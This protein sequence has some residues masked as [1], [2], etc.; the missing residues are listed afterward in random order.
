MNLTD[1]ELGYLAGFID[2][3]GSLI[4]NKREHVGY[5]EKRYISYSAYLDIGNTNKECLEFIKKILNISSSIYENQCSGNRKLAYR[6]RISYKQAKPL[7]EALK[8]RLIVKRKI[9]EVFL[10]YQDKSF[11]KEK[12]FLE[13]KELNKRG[14]F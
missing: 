13:A 6:L 10:N 2:G 9:A 12:L 8:S 7:I 11:D 14:I 3:E 5:N 4:I 1:F